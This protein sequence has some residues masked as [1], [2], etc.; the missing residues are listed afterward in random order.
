MNRRLC[1]PGFGI[2][3]APA[4]F[5]GPRVTLQQAAL[6]AAIPKLEVKEDPWPESSACLI[7]AISVN[8]AII[9]ISVT[10]N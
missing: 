10:I 7:I 4:S 1:E 5:L 8:L 3:L 2:I 9:A 6:L